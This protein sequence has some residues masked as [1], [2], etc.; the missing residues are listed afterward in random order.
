MLGAIA[1]FQCAFRDAEDE[2]HTIIDKLP[3]FTDAALWSDSDYPQP[4]EMRCQVLQRITTSDNQ[5]LARITIAHPDGIES[6]DGKS[7]FV[8][9]EVDLIE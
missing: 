5:K 3:I 9:A 4:G 7:E 2:A 8:V 6:T 1:L